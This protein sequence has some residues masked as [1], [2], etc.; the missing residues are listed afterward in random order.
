MPAG[1]GNRATM[2]SGAMLSPSGVLRF[3]PGRGGAKPGWSGVDEV[4]GCWREAG[5]FRFAS[6][7]EIVCGADGSLGLTRKG[8]WFVIPCADCDG[9]LDS[10]AAVERLGA[11]ALAGD[12]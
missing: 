1:F 4:P 10:D 3:K 11:P 9:T 2:G 12:A 6:N 5:W 8:G 7:A